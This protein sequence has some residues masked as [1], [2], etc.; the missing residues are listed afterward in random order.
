MM[1]QKD[2]QELTNRYGPLMSSR[3]VQQVLRFSTPEGLRAARHRSR[4]VL[5]MFKLPGRKGL[6]ANT[7]DVAKLIE[8]Q[9]EYAQKSTKEEDGNS[10]T[11]QGE[12]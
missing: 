2:I 1:T 5:D 8:Q 10:L 6:F 11:L 7:A 9:V 3:D 12:S 4:L